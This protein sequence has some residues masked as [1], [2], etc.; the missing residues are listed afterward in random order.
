[1]TPAAALGA[2]GVGAGDSD[3]GKAGQAA[4]VRVGD[5]LSE[6]LLRRTGFGRFLFGR[7][8]RDAAVGVTAA[9]VRRS[10]EVEGGQDLAQS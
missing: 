6:D 7:R 1:M 3:G 2:A 9:A 10:H 8:R 4:D 5:G